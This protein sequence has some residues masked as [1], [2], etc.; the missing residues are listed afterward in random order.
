MPLSRRGSGTYQLIEFGQ[1]VLFRQLCWP[2]TCDRSRPGVL[3]G[4]FS[5]L[6]FIACCPE[7][8]HGH[9]AAAVKNLEIDIVAL[10]FL[11]RQA[12]IA[13]SAAPNAGGPADPVRASRASAICA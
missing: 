9:A 4:A 6:T 3:K 10:R 7:Q 11:L 12:G 8:P 1:W 13:L 2:K 5:I